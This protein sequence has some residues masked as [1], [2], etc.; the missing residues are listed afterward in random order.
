M[1]NYKIG[2]IFSIQLPNQKYI[3]GRILLDVN[4]QCVKPKL[5]DPNSPLSSYD[6][7]LLVEIYKELSDNPNFL[8]QEKLIPGFFLMPDPIAEQEW[9]I[10]DHLEVDPQQVEFPE[11][12]FL[13]NGRQVFQRGE[14]RLPIPEQLDENDGWDIYPSITSPYALPKICL[15]YLGLREFLTP[16]QQN[17]MNLER[18]DFRF[19][20]RRSEIYKI[21]QEDENQSYYE[22]ASR[23]GYDITRFYPGNSTIFR[24]KYD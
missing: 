13:Y 9:L 21:I 20:N 8:G 7:C 23:L 10:I 19:S 24:T 15:Y 16:V 6:G 17:T 11:T 4:K 22:I 18:L 2:D 3:F 14:I 12:I 5:I 1:S